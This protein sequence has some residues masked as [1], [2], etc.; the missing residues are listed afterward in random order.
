MHVLVRACELMGSCKTAPS[1]GHACV[2]CVH[3]AVC[4]VAQPYHE[5]QIGH[6]CAGFIGE[7][8]GHEKASANCGVFDNGP[9]TL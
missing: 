2:P 4:I 5:N 3:P 1:G 8:T 6:L 9:I 7:L